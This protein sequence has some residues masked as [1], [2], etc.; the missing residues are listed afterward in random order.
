M[1]RLLGP[2]L[3][4][5]RWFRHLIT[6]S[7]LAR[8]KNYIQRFGI[9]TFIVGRFIPGGR[10][11]LFISTGLTGMPFSR[12][13]MRDSVGCLLSSGL[14]F[15]LGYLFGANFQVIVEVVKMYEKIFL[16]SVGLAVVV[17]ALVFF[18]RYNR[19]K[20]QKY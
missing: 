15:Y 14:L 8:I 10:N 11:A 13:I 7:R 12:F 4:T 5:F 6:P 16:G 18:Y 17:L 9:F 2:R 1:G 19:R 3:F 20:L